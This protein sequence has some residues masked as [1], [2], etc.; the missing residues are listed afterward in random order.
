MK[1]S[2]VIAAP[3][4]EETLEECRRAL[5]GQA[6]DQIVVSQGDGELPSLRWAEID[7]LEGDVIACL[8]ARCIPAPD[9]AER[10]RAAHAA[11]PETIGGVILPSPSASPLELG[12]YFSDHFV[13]AEPRRWARRIS[14]ANVSY[15]RC[16]VDRFRRRLTSGQWETALHAEA[17]QRGELSLAD[18]R[19]VYR[20]QDRPLSEVLTERYCHGQDYGAQSTRRWARVAL[21]PLLPF[22]Q[23]GRAFQ[24]ASRA[25][26]SGAFLRALPWTWTLNTAWALGEAVGGA[27]GVSTNANRH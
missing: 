15:K 3:Y 11:G 8:E 5:E 22:V 24:A 26:L 9:W 25:G 27:R 6:V 1:L 10:I 2:V 14:D 23:T 19:A 4:P 12:Q 7:Q 17:A 13:A 18:A 21:A 20:Y 16:Y